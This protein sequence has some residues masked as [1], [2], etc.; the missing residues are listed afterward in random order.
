LP[1]ASDG[2]GGPFGGDQSVAL[3]VLQDVTNLKEGERLKDDFIG[4]AAHELRTPLAALKGFAEMLTIQTARG[5][6]HKLDDWQ[7]EALDAIDQSTTRL[8]ELI[9]DLL[10]VTRLQGGRL[11]V[12]QE[13]H[14]LVALVRRVIRRMGVMTDHRE[15]KIM[16]AADP[17]I[18]CVDAPRIEQVVSNLV[19]NAIKYSPNGGEV[20]VEVREDEAASDA[21]IAVR[22]HGIGIPAA[23]QPQVFGRFARADNAREMGIGGTGLGLYLSRELVERHGGRVWFESAE[24]KGSTFYVALPLRKDDADTDP[25]PLQTT[26][27]AARD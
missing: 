18:A 9:D 12:H 15:V 4:V 5:K 23:Q 17:V 20:T 3:I 21:I 27:E 10:D 14:D 16:A 26:A 19:S 11:E 13:P 1:P 7:R 2:S 8:V 25:A 24:G 22:D 6:G